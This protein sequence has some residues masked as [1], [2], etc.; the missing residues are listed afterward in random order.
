MSDMKVWVKFLADASGLRR[1]MR[2]SQ[3][4][5]RTLVQSMKRDFNSLKGTLNSIKGTLAGIG[6]AIGVMSQL[7]ASARLDK[8]LMRIGQTAGA[9]RQQMQEMRSEF[10]AM[11]RQ[12]GQSVENLQ[13]GFNSLIQAGLDV[14]EARA[15]ILG[16]NTAMAVTGAQADVLA[17]AL[18]TAQAAFGFDL[19]KSGMALQL[20]DKM[21]V[22]GRMGN[23]ELEDLSMIFGRL[24]VNAASA[25]MSFDKTLAFVEALSLLEKNPER[26]AT[27]ADSTLRV[28]TNMRYM[29]SAQKATGIRFF[30]A[31]GQ[32]RDALAVLNDI[33]AQYAKLK[34]DQERSVFIQKAFGKADLDTIKGLRALMQGDAL[35]KMAAFTGQIGSA[36]G[37][38]DKDLNDA[39][40][41]AVDQTARLKTTLRE[42]A[43]GFARPINNALSQAIKFGLAKKEEGGL[44]LS[45]KDIIFGGGAL[46]AG[47][48]LT[49]FLGN[50][51]AQS[52][53]RRA[54]GTALGIAE[55]KAVEAATGV[56]PVFVTNW[57][58]GFGTGASAASLAGGGKPGMIKTLLD[59]IPRGSTHLLGAGKGLSWL[60]KGLTVAAA[61][62]GTTAAALGAA[63][64]AGYGIGTAINK[65]MGDPAGMLGVKLYDLFHKDEKNEVNL[66]VQIDK[67][68]RV[69]SESED[70]NTHINVRRGAF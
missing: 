57:P 17:G 33:R 60:T 48:L 68:G 34:T 4:Q 9:T 20:L 21:T 11:S 35:E 54:G 58:P 28:F 43:D 64:L 12:T 65:A 26:L 45:G 24:G 8:S 7:M 51:A 10:F 6:I 19:A 31:D 40:D 69:M 47:T 63:G 56:T 37:T 41:N 38:L 59:K 22:A 39:I 30:D 53:A 36:A 29:M 14:R 2:L 1:E 42:A 3:Q 52:I 27:L 16:I 66:N 70:M 5:S 13:E 15:T 18:T 50:K 46:A 49:A 25:G 44:E 62:A 61:G 55:G 67:D 32:R 23:A